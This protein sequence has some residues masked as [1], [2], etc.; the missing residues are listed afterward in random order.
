M[1]VAFG[2][3]SYGTASVSE[4]AMFSRPVAALECSG[5]LTTFQSLGDDYLD[6]P[7]RLTI[8]SPFSA[9]S[10]DAEYRCA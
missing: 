8:S 6:D 10:V 1:F 5:A 4:T 9:I 7:I 3:R 2:D